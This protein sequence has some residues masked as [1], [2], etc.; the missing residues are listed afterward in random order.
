VPLSE[1]APFW[2]HPQRQM[3]I[4]QMLSH[5]SPQEGDQE[6]IRMDTK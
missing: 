5:L 3:T 4:T 6:V 2:K 1:I